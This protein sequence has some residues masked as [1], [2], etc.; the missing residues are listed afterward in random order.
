[1]SV[2]PDRASSYNNVLASA[3]GRS[4]TSRAALGRGDHDPDD[5]GHLVH[6]NHYVCGSMLAYEGDPDYA[7]YRA[8]ATPAPPNC[9]RC[10]AGSITMDTL[11]G[12]LA[13]HEQAPDSLCRH[14]AEGRTT[15]TRSGA[16]PTSPTARSVWAGQ[17][18]RF[19]RT[20]IPVRVERG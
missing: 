7:G 11:H 14:E 8:C 17:P 19:R 3:D 10:A 2:R 4:R 20:G 12:F 18:L 9:W 16:L 13:D 6:T 15:V 1:M 5:D